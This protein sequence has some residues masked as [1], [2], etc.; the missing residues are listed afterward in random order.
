MTNRT[1]ATRGS[2]MRNKCWWRIKMDI[3]S[4]A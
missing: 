2:L 3:F 1:H 4:G